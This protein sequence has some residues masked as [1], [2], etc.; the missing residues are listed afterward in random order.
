M[1]EVG[2]AVQR[3]DD[4]DVVCVRVA[5]RAAGLFGQDAVVRKG[6]EQGF[7]NDGFAGLVD[8]GDEVID[9]LL[10]DSNSLHVQ[11]G[12]VDDGACG[13]CGFDSHI[14]HGVKVGGRHKFLR[15]SKAGARW[16]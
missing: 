4:P 15:T 13:A 11:S 2:G 10:R 6:G 5:V 16:R 14:E 8:F 12:A 7:Q 9:L 1:N 3:I